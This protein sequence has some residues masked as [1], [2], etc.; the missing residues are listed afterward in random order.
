[1]FKSFKVGELFDIHPTNA[2]KMKMMSCLLLQEQ[3]LL[4]P[5]HL[6]ITVL[7]DIVV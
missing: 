4:C 3:L 6:S 2:Y 1:M 7:A 5:T